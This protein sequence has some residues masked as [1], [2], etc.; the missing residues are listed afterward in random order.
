MNIQLTINVPVH[1]DYRKVAVTPT[2]DGCEVF[3]EQAV[4]MADTQVTIPWEQVNDV[5]HLANFFPYEM[6]CVF[7][8]VVELL[9][10]AYK[11]RDVL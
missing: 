5:E 4:D 8:K 2:E 9:G 11:L 1:T 6:V 3:I 7:R 10:K